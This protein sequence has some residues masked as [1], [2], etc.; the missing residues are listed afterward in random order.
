M[1]EWWRELVQCSSRIQFASSPLDSARIHGDAKVVIGKFY[2]IL[3]HLIVRFVNWPPHARLSLLSP[4]LLGRALEN[5]LVVGLLDPATIEYRPPSY[6]TRDCPIPAGLRRR[7]QILPAPFSFET[8]HDELR[9]Y[10]RLREPLFSATSPSLLHSP[11]SVSPFSS[12]PLNKARSYILST[13][14]RRTKAWLHDARLAW[15]PLVADF[16]H[17]APT[18]L[19]PLFELWQGHFSRA[20]VLPVTFV[21][22]ISLLF[23]V[24]FSS[25]QHLV[26]IF[27][28]WIRTLGMLGGIISFSSPPLSNRILHSQVRYCRHFCDD[29]CLGWNVLIAHLCFLQQL[30]LHWRRA[31]CSVCGSASCLPTLVAAWVTISSRSFGSATTLY[32]HYPD[33]V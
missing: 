25:F 17:Q 23:G 7:R 4:S 29:E 12:S 28:K 27:L 18:K 32:R 20:L 5:E 33:I 24:H 1:L 3:F 13:L 26:I 2:P 6:P 21:T 16:W 30:W 10:Y 9:R 15:W 31:T 19:H 22:C 11:A 14:R 8:S